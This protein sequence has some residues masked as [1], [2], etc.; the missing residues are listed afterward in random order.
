LNFQS[1]E[2]QKSDTD[3]QTKIALFLLKMENIFFASMKNK[4]LSLPGKWLLFI[5][6]MSW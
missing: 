3:K 4:E 2:K 5:S 1:H 6:A